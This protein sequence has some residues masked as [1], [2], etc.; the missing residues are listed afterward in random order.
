[1]SL[2]DQV[3]SMFGSESKGTGG[4]QLNLISGVLEMLNTGGQGGLVGL[5]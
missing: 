1:M 2:F 3:S 5:V 4:D